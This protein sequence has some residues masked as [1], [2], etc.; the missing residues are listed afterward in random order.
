[1]EDDTVGDQMVVLEDLALLLPVVG[2]NRSIAAE[3]HPLGKTIVRLTLVSRC[4]NQGAQLRA[5][6]V[7]KQEF[8]SQRTA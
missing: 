7:L 2:S 1:V 5:V 4:L 8:R 6:E 3:R